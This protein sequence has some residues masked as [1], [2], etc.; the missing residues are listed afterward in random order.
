VGAIS[1]ADE[2]AAWCRALARYGGAKEAVALLERHWHKVPEAWIAGAAVAM[3]ET[4]GD[5]GVGVEAPS[6]AHPRHQHVVRPDLQPHHQ[7]EIGGGGGNGF[8]DAVAVLEFLQNRSMVSRGGDAAAELHVHAFRAVDRASHLKPAH[9]LLAVLEQSGGGGRGAPSPSVADAYRVLFRK[10]RQLGKWVH[11]LSL[12]EQ[13]RGEGEARHGGGGGQGRGGG[14]A[15]VAIDRE[16]AN[17]VLAAITAVKPGVTVSRS[18]KLLRAVHS[19]MADAGLGFDAAN[20]TQALT[21]CARSVARG[22]GL[23]KHRDGYQGRAAVAAACFDAPQM[24]AQHY[25]EA[26]DAGLHL[27]MKMFVAMLQ[28]ADKLGSAASAEQIWADIADFGFYPN[29]AAYLAMMGA[30]GHADDFAGMERILEEAKAAP[31]VT[32]SLAI[33]KC[34]LFHYGRTKQADK[35][36]EAYDLMLTSGLRPDQSLCAI[37][38]HVCKIDPVSV[39]SALK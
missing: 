26:I 29:H 8:S 14:A 21:I 3:L 5:V 35:V 19:D 13:M 24:A 10:Q 7:M 28:I 33:I 23:T 2:H 27:N 20:C 6:R 9:Q 16:M 15:T 11:A 31:T 22:Y 34:L 39:L 17:M 4:L 25:S 37:L 12:Y 32:M 30:L 38:I 1:T 18:L 36:D